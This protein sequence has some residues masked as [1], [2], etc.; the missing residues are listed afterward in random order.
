MGLDT[1]PREELLQIIAQLEQSIYNYQQWRN[2]LLRTLICK[3]TPDKHDI[4]PQPHKDCRFGQWYYSEAHK[5]LQEDAGFLAL[6][7]E[8]EHMHQ[9]ASRLLCATMLGNTIASHEYDNFANSVERVQLQLFSLK[10]ELEYLLYNRD[11]LTHAI[12][13]V[14]MPLILREQQEI[15]KRQVYSC[16]IVMMDLDL[17][18]QTNDTYGH[19]AGDLVLASVVRYLTQN[20]RP[21]DKAFRYGGEEFLICLTDLELQAGFEMIERIRSGLAEYKIDIGNSKTVTITASFGVA[22]LDP[23]FPIEYSIDQADKA[24]LAAKASGRNCARLWVD[25][26]AQK[27]GV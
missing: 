14:N 2:M 13:R 1:V 15:A 12:N 9:L 17:F 5:N 10:Q 21:Y 19:I 25:P 8:H 23:N 11:P 27:I 6:G 24:M 4:G 3:L 20:L 16:I 26:N 22:R 18:K 7:V